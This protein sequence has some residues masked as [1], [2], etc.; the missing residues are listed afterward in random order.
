MKDTW[1]FIAVTPYVYDGEELFRVQRRIDGSMRSIVVKADRIGEAAIEL[2]GIPVP[3]AKGE[4]VLID[5]PQTQ[6]GGGKRCPSCGYDH[7]T[8]PDC[9]GARAT[10]M[11]GRT[12]V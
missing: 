6:T 4:A 12:L 10:Y 8:I 1:S 9:E 5:V 3:D 7:G 2:L 11:R